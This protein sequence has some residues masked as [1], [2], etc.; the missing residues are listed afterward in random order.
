MVG[1]QGA[2]EPYHEKHL[3]LNRWQAARLDAFLQRL[4]ARTCLRVTQSELMRGLLLVVHRNE[5]AILEGAL[6]MAEQVKGHPATR[7]HTGQERHEE[8]LADLMER[9]VRKA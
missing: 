7:D 4:E 9:A 6:S 1:E 8:R 3:L 5:A 2:R